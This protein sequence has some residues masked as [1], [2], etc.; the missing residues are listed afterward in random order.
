MERNMTA[1]K[2]F[3]ELAGIGKAQSYLDF[4]DIFP[5]Y[6]LPLY[7]DPLVF[8]KSDDDLSNDCADLIQDFFDSVIKA[9]S[10]R[11]QGRAVSLLAN[12]SEPNEVCLGVSNEGN[13]GRG[14]G[15]KQ[16]IQL[17]H[18]ISNSS[19]GQSGLIQDLSD[20]DLFVPNIGKDK[21]SDITTNIIKLRLI[22]YTQDQCKLHDIDIAS[23]TF[24][25]RNYWSK[26]SQ[27]WEDGEFYLPSFDDMR[28]IILVPK[29][30][31]R[32]EMS[33]ESKS[34]YN[35]DIIYHIAK[36]EEEDP[37][38]GF[39]RVLKNGHRKPEI[40][41]I[42]KKYKFSKKFVGEISSQNPDIYKKYKDERIR[43]V[44]LSTLLDGDII[45]LA[46]RLGHSPVYSRRDTAKMLIELLQSIHAGNEQAHDFNTLVLGVITFLFYPVL[47]N[48]RS[49]VSISNGL[50]RVDAMFTNRANSGFFGGLA[51]SRHLPCRDII[52]ECKNLSGDMGNPEV[53]QI[54]GRLA[55][56]TGRFGL[57]ICRE[58]ANPTRLLERCRRYSS[59]GNF[60]VPLADEDLIVMLQMVVD[61]EEE[62]IEFF[63]DEKF[64]QLS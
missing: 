46:S 18:A 63:M 35:K 13:N 25:I 23:K 39:V 61:G 54:N 59:N 3:S 62:N 29:F 34:F 45:A 24:M 17:F 32:R 2:R 47:V 44:T 16:A 38:S 48:P 36:R 19:A 15:K 9:V 41:K 37:S 10:S 6:D 43:S 5:G 50:K 20:L 27:S 53:D 21:V 51:V 1:P 64:R 28:P 4:V 40:G 11:N 56:T 30:L 55:D 33:L 22:E 49:E 14:I 57:L 12:L 31:V 58:I 8:A 26:A 7:I 52:V 60:I 42:R